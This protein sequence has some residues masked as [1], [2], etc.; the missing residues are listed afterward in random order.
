MYSDNEVEDIEPEDKVL[1]T[2]CVSDSY[3]KKIIRKGELQYCSYCSEKAPSMLL[4]K[5]ADLIETGI[6]TVYERT[7]E[8][9][10]DN[11]NPYE[12]WYRDG[13]EIENLIPDEVGVEP[14][15]ARDIQI[16]LK[17]KY[18]RYDHDGL[19]GECEFDDGSMYQPRA[20][21]DAEY[22]QRW[23]KFK[24]LVQQ[25]TL[26]AINERNSILA[27]IFAGLR[28]L[29]DYSGKAAIIE[30]GPG[31]HITKLYRARAFVKDQI[32]LKALKAPDRELGTPAPRSARAGRMNQAGDPVF[33]GAE[34]PETT[35]REVRPPVG[36]KVAVAGFELTRK[37]KILDMTVMNDV[38]EG[39]SI[40]DPNSIAKRVQTAFLKKFSS[41]IAIPV[42]PDEGEIEY[43]PTQ[44][45]AMFLADKMGLDGIR[46]PSVQS[47]GEEMNITLFPHASNVERIIFPNGSEI[48][49]GLAYEDEKHYQ[50]NSIYITVPRGEKVTN[51]ISRERITSLRIDTNSIVIHQVQRS[52]FTCKPTDTDWIEEEERSFDDTDAHKLFGTQW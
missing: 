23:D 10:G 50:P 35:I 34:L 4:T 30:I 31:T 21:D 13:E 37:L 46:F 26:N 15:I 45:V 12:T 38:Y 40:F 32:L 22:Y 33:Y 29:K 1:C 2:D 16:I 18:Y 5:I 39:G 8:D 17:G 48:H 27:Q 20:L 7:P 36:S 3:L 6:L 24:E 9:P 41:L 49:T 52:N 42:M 11:Y 44:K 47:G 51:E 25:T 19:Y 43:V 14:N 28:D